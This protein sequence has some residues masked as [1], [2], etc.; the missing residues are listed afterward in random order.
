MMTQDYMLDLY[1]DSGIYGFEPW[2][3]MLCGEITDPVILAN[4]E[5]GEAYQAELEQSVA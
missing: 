5:A 2:R 1:D 3:C 4:R